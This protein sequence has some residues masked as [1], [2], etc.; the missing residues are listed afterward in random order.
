MYP[1][2]ES[3]LD[4]FM[5]RVEWVISKKI[6][7]E[8]SFIHTKA[9]GAVARSEAPPFWGPVVGTAA[10]SETGSYVDQHCFLLVGIYR[11]HSL[12]CQ[13]VAWSV[14]ACR[15]RLCR[16]GSRVRFYFRT[17]ICGRRRRQSVGHGRARTPLG[18]QAASNGFQRPTTLPVHHRRNP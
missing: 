6:W 8:T 16:D 10:T 14:Y 5:V 17:W 4:R 1:L 13:L 11:C 18:A 3:Q 15:H 9:I 7:S 2:P 12:P